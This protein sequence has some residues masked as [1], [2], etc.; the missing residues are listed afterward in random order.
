MTIA[1][2]PAELPRPER[3]SW[4][5]QRLDGR[6]KSQSEAPTPQ[7]RKRFSRVGK[8]VSLSVLLTRD[9]KAIFDRFYEQDTSDGALLFR[10]PDPTTDEWP[11]LGSD[12]QPLLISGGADDG[13]PLLLAGQ[14]LCSFGDQLPSEAVTG[15]NFR[16]SFDVVVMP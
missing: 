7:Y 5:N 2:W 4:N 3:S 11:L 14:W 16:I 13:K 12:G 1:I 9:E 8:M 15:V 6:R 10:M